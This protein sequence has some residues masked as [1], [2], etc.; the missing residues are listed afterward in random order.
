MKPR[1][2]HTHTVYYETRQLR[3]F[4]NFHYIFL[5]RVHVDR[6]P[7]IIRGLTTVHVRKHAMPRLPGVHVT[8]FK[9]LLRTTFMC[10][11][12]S[13]YSSERKSQKKERKKKRESVGA[14]NL[15]LVTISAAD[16]SIR[17]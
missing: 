1:N 7:L 9:K 4:E 17:Y 6:L 15:K 5:M 11:I 8:C 3:I 16:Q 12:S 14:C 10:N 13:V 2:L